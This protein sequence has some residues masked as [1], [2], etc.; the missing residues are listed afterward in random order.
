MEE[1]TNKKKAPDFAGMAKNVA[2]RAATA[3]REFIRHSAANTG[4]PSKAT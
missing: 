4:T 3:P 1:I 2:Q